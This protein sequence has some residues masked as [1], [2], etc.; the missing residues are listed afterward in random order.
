MKECDNYEAKLDAVDY[1]L[2]NLLILQRFNF[3]LVCRF[4]R[5]CF[6]RNSFPLGLI[7]PEKRCEFVSSGFI[8]FFD[9]CLL[10]FFHAPFFREINCRGSVCRIIVFRTR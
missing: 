6:G 1:K 10:W 8:D 2:R 5:A 3:H 4:R 9:E 7:F